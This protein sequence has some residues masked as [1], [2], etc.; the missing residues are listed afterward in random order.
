M[1]KSTHVNNGRVWVIYIE[2]A[3]THCSFDRPLHDRASTKQHQRVTQ[4]DRGVA[5]YDR[6]RTKEHRHVTKHDRD[7]TK[8]YQHVTQ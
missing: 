3:L 2:M 4:C 1:S 5:L 7:R 8:E 6:D